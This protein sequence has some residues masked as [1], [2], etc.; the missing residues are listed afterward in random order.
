MKTDLV[1][2]DFAQRIA[3]LEEYVVAATKGIVV[4]RSMSS[5]DAAVLLLVE[6]FD[7]VNSVF[8]S[9]NDQ[10]LEG[11]FSS[12]SKPIFATKYSF[13]CIFEDYFGLHATPRRERAV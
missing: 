12:V 10:T 4:I 5:P 3:N 2:G 6:R 11:S 1:A 7:A 8:F 13:F 9:E